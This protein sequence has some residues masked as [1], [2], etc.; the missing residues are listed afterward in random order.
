MDIF[1]FEAVTLKLLS[2]IRVGHDGKHAGAGWFLD[3][4]VVKQDGSDKYTQT[5]SCNRWLAIDEDDGLI[6]REITAGG[7]D[8][9]HE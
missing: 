5:F 7:V 9:S 1:T 3:K 6:I 2:K 4:V 8:N